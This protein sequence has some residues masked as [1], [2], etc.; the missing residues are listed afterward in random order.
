ML[1]TRS[2]LPKHCSWN[3]DQHGKRRVRFRKDGFSTYLTGTAWS[4]DFMCQHAAALDGVKVQAAAGEIGA[5]RTAPGS[6]NA[7][8]VSYYRS[9][10][11]RAL[12]PSTE[13]M[14]RNIIER[15]R[16][17][18]GDKRIKGLARAHLKALIGA[19]A[20]TPHAANNLLKVL[21]VLLGYAVSID[22]I[23]SNPAIGVK[24]YKASGDGFYSWTDDEV[25]QFKARHP[26]GTRAR[27]AFALLRYTAQ[28][29]GDVVKMGRQDVQRDDEGEFIVMRQNKTGTKMGIP[30]RPELAEALAAMLR[31]NMTFLT[32]EQGAPFTAAGFGNWFRDRCNEA[33]LPQCSAHGLRKVAATV[34]ANAGGSGD[35]IKAVTGH[36]SLAEVAHYTRSVDQLRLARQ[37]MALELRAERE[38]SDPSR[39]RFTCAL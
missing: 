19:K 10:D 14:R 16:A 13:S 23:E 30:I 4:E 7:L 31:S 11:F 12:K 17:A 9:P 27:L 39:Q 24:K 5:A 21:R 6:F 3:V 34:V 36:K 25:E 15:F 26:V 35:Q 22:M 29:R 28:R 32:T 18:H 37:T 33:G 1:R 38:Q 20:D 8:C 2:G